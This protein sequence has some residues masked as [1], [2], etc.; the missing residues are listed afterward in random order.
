[1]KLPLNKALLVVAY[2]LI[3]DLQ[4]DMHKFKIEEMQNNYEKR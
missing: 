4:R 3:M 2:F 1:M